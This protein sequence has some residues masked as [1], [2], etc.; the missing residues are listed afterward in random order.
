VINQTPTAGARLLHLPA[1]ERSFQP[2]ASMTRLFVLALFVAATAFAVVACTAS[3]G[4]AQEGEGEGAAGGEGEG[5]GAAACTAMV[6]GAWNATGPAFGMDMTTTT[7]F[8]SCAATFTNWNM[9]MSTPTGAT[10]AGTAVTFTGQGWTDCTGTLSAD[11][12]TING[13]CS[14]GSALTMTAQ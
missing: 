6:P 9:A 12:K 14:D 11:G 7:A 10:V 2:E 8:A 13:Q 1:G 3:P 5:E 4:P